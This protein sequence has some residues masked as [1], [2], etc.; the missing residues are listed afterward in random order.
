MKHRR[1]IKTSA[2]LVAAIA[3]LAINSSVVADPYKSRSGV[4]AGVQYNFVSID[5]GW[6]QLGVE[7]LSGKIGVQPHPLLGL[8]GRLGYSTDDRRLRG[9]D[10][11][12]DN[13]VGAYV[14]LNLANK[15]PITPYFLLGA[16][17]VEIT[18]TSI[19]GTTTEEDSDFSF[20][21]GLDVEFTRGVSGNI[22]YLQYYDNGTTIIDGMGL[23]VTFRF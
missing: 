8:E 17:H 14:T 1:T 22:E 23:G 13:T 16:S 3:L 18:A 12:L 5:D 2:L 9:V 4:Y 19:A 20:G 11:A 10:Y 7:T 6:D 21:A 15:S